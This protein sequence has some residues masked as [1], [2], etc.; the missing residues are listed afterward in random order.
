MKWELIDINTGEVIDTFR[1]LHIAYEVRD[2]LNRPHL[3]KLYAVR[4][5]RYDNAPT[6]PHH[7]GKIWE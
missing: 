7:G 4:E 2:D 3:D 5:A 6:D 1:N